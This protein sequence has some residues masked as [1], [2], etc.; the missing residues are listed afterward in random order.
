MFSWLVDYLAT[1]AN[2]WTYPLVMLLVIL[3]ASLFLGFLLPGEAPLIVG[4]VLAGREAISLWGI[5]A[6]AASGAVAGDSL[7]YVLGKWIGEDRAVRWGSRV[8]ITRERMS[9]ADK[10][11]A[12]HGGKAI[13]LGRFASVFRPVVPFV[14][15]ASGLPYARFSLY[16]VPAGV[17]WAAT[18]IGLGY[19][20][21]NEWRSVA[22]WVDIA[23]WIILVA[24][25]L[26]I[27]W[28][29]IS[30]RSVQA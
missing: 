1:S 8:G 18:F 14:A 5:G 29:W 19:W 23:G 15:G 6:I 26:F 7:S 2:G 13:F 9:R 25:V 3:D 10:F 16:N 21:G 17:V 30:N 4:G 22:R 11:F 20:A 24:I 12:A 27:L 28:R